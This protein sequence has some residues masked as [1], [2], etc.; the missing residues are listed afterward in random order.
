LAA[1][2]SPDRGSASTPSSLDAEFAEVIE[3]VASVEWA[4]SDVVGRRTYSIKLP[5]SPL[6]LTAGR[7]G[8]PGKPSDLYASLV[9]RPTEAPARAFQALLD[10][11]TARAPLSAGDA[12]A[13]LEGSWT[14]EPP[15]EPP[16]EGSPARERTAKRL[17]AVMTIVLERCPPQGTAINNP[18]AAR[19]TDTDIVAMRSEEARR[20]ALA[21]DAPVKLPKEDRRALLLGQAYYFDQTADGR[22]PLGK[23]LIGAAQE[24][25]VQVDRAFD[26]AAVKPGPKGMVFDRLLTT[27]EGKLQ[28]HPNGWFNAIATKDAIYVSPTI[29]RAALIACAAEIGIKP[30]YLAQLR[31][32]QE[33]L[34]SR[35][36]APSDALS[37]LSGAKR[38]YAKALDC[39]ADQLTFFIAHEVAHQRLGTLSEDHADCAGAA[40]A[41]HLRRPVPGVFRELIFDLAGSGDEDLL[42][43]SPA[44]LRERL[45]GEL[46]C[47]RSAPWISEAQPDLVELKGAINRCLTSARRCGG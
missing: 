43:L 4:I 20:E 38:E 39:V 9:Q 35:H 2:Q 23:F 46:T 28:S 16:F 44:S 6:L 32:T 36:I 25:F 27:I 3:K 17:D 31:R 19:P 45:A 37:D 24:T 29:V 42:G 1:R 7:V 10:R 15:A 22:I 30:S 14:D 5:H 33:R 8:Q 12:S 40:V 47:R 13:C 41:R 11:A 18:A 34:L 21:V 26:L